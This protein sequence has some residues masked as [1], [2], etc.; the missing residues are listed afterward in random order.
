MSKKNKI[1]QLAIANR[2]QC[3][4]KND[5]KSDKYRKA[6]YGYGNHHWKDCPDCH[7]A[8]GTS[9]D[10]KNSKNDGLPTSGENL[11]AAATKTIDKQ[12]TS[13]LKIGQKQR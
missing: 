6:G 5:P 13:I 11:D 10:N 7:G 9:K 1:N 3:Q 12:P 4:Q 2:E 8:K